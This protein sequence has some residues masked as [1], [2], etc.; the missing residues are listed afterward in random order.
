MIEFVANKG[1]NEGENCSNFGYTKQLNI[2]FIG[3]NVTV[4]FSSK[5][6]IKGKDNL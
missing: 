3:P 2:L 6:I 4:L 5:E 1:V